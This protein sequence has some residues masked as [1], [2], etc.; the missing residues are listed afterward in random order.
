MDRGDAGPRRVPAGGARLVAQ[1]PASAG[2]L[3]L[4]PPGLYGVIGLFLAAPTLSVVL[5]P[6]LP[7]G[8][9]AF[10]MTAPDRL[11]PGFQF[12]SATARTIGCL[13]LGYGVGQSVGGQGDSTQC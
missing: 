7:P 4:V 6:W 12:T 2:Y 10:L 5:S 8:V 13:L 11:L 9:T 3:P 1:A